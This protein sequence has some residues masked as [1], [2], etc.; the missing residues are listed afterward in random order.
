[1]RPHFCLYDKS[2]SLPLLLIEVTSR[3]KSKYV[4]NVSRCCSNMIYQFRCLRNYTEIESIFGFVYPYNKDATFVTKIELTWKNC[5]FS[6]RFHFIVMEN[7]YTIV[8]DVLE[9]QCNDF[10]EYKRT[11]VNS[12]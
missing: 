11:R 5:T 6:A 9:K 12:S 1:M 2:K 10:F 4:D 8:S 3:G 7:V